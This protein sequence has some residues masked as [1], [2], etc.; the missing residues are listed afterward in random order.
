MSRL[1]MKQ[2]PAEREAEEDRA[3]R[4]AQRAARKGRPSYS[5][6]P[7]HSDRKHKRKHSRSPSTRK[8]KRR[9]PSPYHEPGLDEGWVPPPTSSKVDVDAL[10]AEMEERRFRE[11]LFDAMGDDA[12]LDGAE[13]H[14]NDYAYVPPRWT[15]SRQSSNKLAGEDLTNMEDEQYAEWVR[16]GMWKRT[17]RAEVEAQ[18]RAEEERKKRK[19]KEKARRE[20]T[21]KMEQEAG[22]RRARRQHAK[23][24]QHAVNAWIAYDERWAQLRAGQAQPEE[25]AFTD[26]PWP[27]YPPPRLP[28]P[29]EALSRQ[30]ISAFLLSP[31]HSIGKPRRQRL[32]EAL[33]LYHPDRFMAKW[34]GIIREV[35]AP[36][37]KEAVG[38][39]ARVLT[40]LVEEGDQA[41]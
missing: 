21:R 12:G 16:E 27:T 11:K 36:S 26:L 17:H 14:Y 20:E 29:P 32:R 8:K 3:W 6:N 25:L 28:L 30:A 5:D 18:E 35:D 4:K 2:T 37:V 13:A 23:E 40:G 19:E 22:E 33:L 10:C 15:D 24:Q 1:H 39:V 7:S 9:S 31:L 34:M 41:D 38:R